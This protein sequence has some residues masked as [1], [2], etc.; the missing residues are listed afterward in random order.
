MSAGSPPIVA[1][2]GKGGVGKTVVSALLARAW[3]DAATRPV[4]LVDADPVGGL[5]TAIGVQPEKT[6]GS[7]RA[8]LI[9]AARAAGDEDAKQRV[10]EQLDYLVLETLQERGDHAL[11]AMGRTT[12][13]GCYCSVNTLLRRALELI[14]APFAAVLIDAEAGLEQINRQVTRRV[15]HTLV[16]TDGSRRSLD[17]LRAV[18]ETLG[19]E[20]VLAVANRRRGMD[21]S[22]PAGS[23]PAGVRALG[24]LPEDDELRRYDR[25]GRSLWTLPEANPAR[26]AARE[27]AAALFSSPEV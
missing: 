17:T 23:L 26:Q 25:E 15:S 20:R 2:C 8:E 24:G 6:L 5:T 10:A 19:P 27:L 13:R 12:E 1:V 3:L 21:E 4:L 11:I 22:F 14:V 16:V 7:V 18:T 9:A